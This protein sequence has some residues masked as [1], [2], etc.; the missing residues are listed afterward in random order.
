V[1]FR[2]A[3]TT[4]KQFSEFKAFPQV[5]SAALNGRGQFLSSPLGAKFE[6]LGVKLV[7]K[8]EVIQQG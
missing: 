1:A 8:G 6:G 4:K 2:A 3:T 7:P 5:E